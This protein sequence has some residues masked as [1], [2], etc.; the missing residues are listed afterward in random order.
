MLVIPS[1]SNVDVYFLIQYEKK[2]G[3]N[4]T[5]SSPQTQFLNNRTIQS[6]VKVYVDD[7]VGEY[8]ALLTLSFLIVQT[9]N[10]FLYTLSMHF[11]GER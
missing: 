8:K 10:E 1:P 2:G 9:K 6:F 11:Q 5:A 4:L 3:L 7:Y